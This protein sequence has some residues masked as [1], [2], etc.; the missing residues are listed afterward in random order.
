MFSSRCRAVRLHSWRFLLAVI[1]LSVLATGVQAQND[2]APASTT[3]PAS[4]TSAAT[5]A[6]PS[7]ALKLG[8]G[9]LVDMSVYNVPELAT[10]TRVSSNGEMYCPLIGYMHVGGMTAEEAQAA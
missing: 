3:Q 6:T 8:P 5:S 7:H 10:T 4:A 1:P 2:A 9:D